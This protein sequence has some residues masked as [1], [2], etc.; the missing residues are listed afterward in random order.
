MLTPKCNVKKR[1][2]PANHRAGGRSHARASHSPKVNLKIKNI[3]PGS[4]DAYLY[5][6]KMLRE[7]IEF[8]LESYGRLLGT[9]PEKVIECMSRMVAEH[10]SDNFDEDDLEGHPDQR[11]YVDEDFFRPDYYE[12]QQEMK[13][14]F[15]KKPSAWARPI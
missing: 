15:K 13:E 14:Y 6:A 10:A 4:K 3:V 1:V 12:M 7:Q 9:D 11:T 2:A 5:A 8:E